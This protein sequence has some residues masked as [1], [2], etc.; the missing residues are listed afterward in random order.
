MIQ[1]PPVSR[2]NNSLLSFPSKRARAVVEICFSVLDVIVVFIFSPHFFTTLPVT[3]LTTLLV[4][5]LVTLSTALHTCSSV[6]LRMFPA[7]HA[8]TRGQLPS[9][10]RSQQKTDLWQNAQV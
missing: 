6:V 8:T 3:L 5:W 2:I 10:H 9:H 4:I 7:R 1:P